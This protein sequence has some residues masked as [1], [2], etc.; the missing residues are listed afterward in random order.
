MVNWSS[1]AA[2]ADIEQRITKTTCIRE[3][4]MAGVPARDDDSSRC[5]CNSSMFI[6]ALRSD[7]D[8]QRDSPDGKK[9]K[10]TNYL[11]CQFVKL[12]ICAE[13]NSLFCHC[14]KV[15]VMERG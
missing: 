10:Q 7:H 5:A 11:K 15:E 13:T 14:L 9:S 8:N 1:Q 12:K 3:N 4:A 2:I 6:S